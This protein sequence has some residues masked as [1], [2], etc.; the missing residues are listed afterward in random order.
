MYCQSLKLIT[1][2]I[3]RNG[4]IEDLKAPHDYNARNLAVGNRVYLHIKKQI[5]GKP[6]NIFEVFLLSS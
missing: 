1:A 2:I 5:T 4:K 3:F 6:L